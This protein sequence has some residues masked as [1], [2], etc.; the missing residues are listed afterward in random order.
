MNYF[1]YTSAYDEG[2]R[3]GNLFRM[4]ERKAEAL[5]FYPGPFT[6]GHSMC[7]PGGMGRHAVRLAHHI[8]R[9]TLPG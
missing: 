7:W 4:R 9:R 2:R 1:D 3:L 6:M 8:A 5:G